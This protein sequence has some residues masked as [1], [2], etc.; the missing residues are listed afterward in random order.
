[1]YAKCFSVEESR[2]V[3]DQM[4]EKNVITWSSMVS[5]Y[6]QSH[7]PD[8]AIFIAKKMRS[9]G[10]KLNEVTYNSLLSSFSSP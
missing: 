10:V 9:V 5:V 4:P 3:F 7:Q 6:A 1:M 2:K 8:E